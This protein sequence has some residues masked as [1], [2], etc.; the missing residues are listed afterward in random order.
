MRR[1]PGALKEFMTTEK[2]PWRTF[3]DRGE[4]GRGWNRPATPA[5]YLI[6][7]EGV[8][9]EK[10]VGNPGAAVMDATVEKWVRMAEEA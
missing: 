1:E 6:D 3:D 7:H 4:I 8:I 9:R 2:L 5:Y 10:W